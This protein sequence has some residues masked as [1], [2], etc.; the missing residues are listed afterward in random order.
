MRGDSLATVKNNNLFEQIADHFI[1]YKENYY[2]LKY[3]YVRNPEDALDIV[4]E[5]AYKAI[6][7]AESLKNPDY[8]K[9]WLYRIVVNTSLDFLPDI[10]I[11]LL[12]AK[13]NLYLSS[14]EKHIRIKRKIHGNAD[15]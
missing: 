4:Q 1:K 6:S 11:W 8:I 13:M 9:T 14:K 10:R 5:S 3:S 2:R 7:S 12:Y 15:S